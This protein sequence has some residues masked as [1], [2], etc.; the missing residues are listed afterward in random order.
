MF[1]SNLAN[2]N[3]VSDFP[4]PKNFNGATSFP[5]IFIS[6]LASTFPLLLLLLENVRLA[7]QNWRKH[8][9]LC[10]LSSVERMSKHDKNIQKLTKRLQTEHHVYGCFFCQ[11]STPT[12]D[13]ATPVSYWCSRAKKI[14]AIDVTL[15]AMN[16][17]LP[18][19]FGLSCS[20]RNDP[21]LLHII[22]IKVIKMD[23]KIVSVVCYG[24]VLMLCHQSPPFLLLPCFC[25]LVMT[26]QHRAQGKN[27][28]WKLVRF[29]PQLRFQP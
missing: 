15:F 8:D 26:K 20:S 29:S 10:L 28:C 25:S 24:K 6:V 13:S 17:S 22:T 5:R 12:L 16:A 11:H 3:A 23:S 4:E 21:S 7:F 18:P 27:L 9:F 14:H 1:V 2:K 19:S